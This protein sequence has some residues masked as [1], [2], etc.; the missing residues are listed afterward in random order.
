VIGCN[1]AMLYFDPDRINII[2]EAFEATRAIL[3]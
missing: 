2:I 3:E 1:P